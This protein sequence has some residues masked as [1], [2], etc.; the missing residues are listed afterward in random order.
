[1][2][3]HECFLFERVQDGTFPMRATRLRLL[4]QDVSIPGESDLS[5][6]ERQGAP[7]RLE[8]SSAE[9]HISDMLKSSFC[10]S[11]VLEIRQQQKCERKWK[12][13]MGWKAVSVRWIAGEV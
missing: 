6:K 5:G 11:G 9:H 13:G 3:R 10:V 1:M 4:M 2:V 8:R 12:D 7:R